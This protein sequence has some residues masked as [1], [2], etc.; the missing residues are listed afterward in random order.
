[1]KTYYLIDLLLQTTILL[2]GLIYAL[3]QFLLVGESL[4]VIVMLMIVLAITNLLSAFIQ[5]FVNPNKMLFQYW[6]FVIVY[7]LFHY[8]KSYYQFQFS[9]AI[10]YFVFFIPALSLAAFYSFQ[11]YMQLKFYVG[12]KNI[13]LNDNN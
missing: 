4:D 2:F 6:A 10:D 1:M 11:L 3:I 8:L 13:S 7:F 5:I 12:K 9:D